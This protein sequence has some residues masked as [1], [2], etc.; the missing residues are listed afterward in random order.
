MTLNALNGSKIEVACVRIKQFKIVKPT[1]FRVEPIFLT[2][3]KF[4]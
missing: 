2:R 3:E 4:K 1:P